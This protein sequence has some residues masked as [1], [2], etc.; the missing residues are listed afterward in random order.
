ME[1]K[2][3]T[4][5]GW[6]EG[7]NLGDEALY[8]ANKILF[9]DHE[10]VPDFKRHGQQYSKIT[11]LGGG[12]LIPFVSYWVRPNRYNYAFGVG[13]EPEAFW[14]EFSP[15]EAIDRVEKFN[16]RLIGVRGKMSYEALERWGLSSEVIG[17]PALL[18]E[19]T[20]NIKRKDDLVLVNL[21]SIKR[22]WGQEPER[23][24]R[25]MIELCKNLKT[26]GFDV[27]LLPFCIEDLP[28]NKRIADESGVEIFNARKDIQAT[29]DFI[30]SSQVVIGERLHSNIFSACA[31]TPFIMIAYRPKC[32]DFVDTVGLSKYVLRTDEMSSIRII[33][34]F[35]DMQRNW[36]EIHTKLVENV[37]M[38]RKRLRDFS[39]R[40]IE[41]IESLPEDKWDPPS[42]LEE[43]RWRLV[44]QPDRFLHYKAYRIW[45]SWHKL[46]SMHLSAK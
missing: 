26:D 39:A 25:E 13:V 24:H 1:K 20:A 35:R 32:F 16:F 28:L 45:R 4:Y 21:A 7:E 41:D 43:L 9:R 12:T 34:L 46:M 6:L 38:Y 18:L 33:S 22:I 37:G 5:I 36:D 2:R 40:I 44:A 17:D 3:I 15:K 10:L 42:R 31:A 14:P 19:P 23:V 29:L 8:L 11:V 27:F 30:A